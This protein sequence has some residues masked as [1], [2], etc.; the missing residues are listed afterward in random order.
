MPLVNANV[1]CP[2]GPYGS[3]GPHMA[4][5]RLLLG[6]LGVA[7]GR[8]KAP[9]GCPW[10]YICLNWELHMA[11][12]ELYMGAYG[13]P[14]AAYGC[15]EDSLGWLWGCIWLLRGCNGLPMGLHMA[16]QRLHL[17]AEGLHFA[18]QGL[19][20]APM[21]Q[22]CSICCVWLGHAGHPGSREYAQM[23]VVSSSGAPNSRP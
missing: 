10:G 1:G 21:R 8:S 17:A 13:C 9:Y 11:T 4:A 20:V 3:H 14:K 16:G 23:V 12:K 18:A 19:S 22:I 5:Q 15:S 2:G 7:Y 6:A